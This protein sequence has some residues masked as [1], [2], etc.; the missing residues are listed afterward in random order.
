MHV[1]RDMIS[2]EKDKI[3]IAPCFLHKTKRVE[4]LEIRKKSAS[5]LHFAN[6][7]RKNISYLSCDTQVEFRSQFLDT[8]RGN[9]GKTERPVHWLPV[10]LAFY[11]RGKNE[12]QKVRVNRRI[13]A[14]RSWT[15]VFAKIM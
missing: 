11:C 8:A 6:C 14:K 5:L 2:S 13:S 10:P 4:Q 15:E 12:H 3:L 1:S 7:T 9:D